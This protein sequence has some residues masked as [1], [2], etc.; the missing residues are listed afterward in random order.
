MT[1]LTASRGSLILQMDHDNVLCQVRSG[2]ALSNEVDALKTTEEKRLL[3]RKVIESII[4]HPETMCV[5]YAGNINWGSPAAY[6]KEAYV[7]ATVLAAPLF[8]QITALNDSFWF[9]F[10]QRDETDIY[11]KTFVDILKENGVAAELTDTFC[12][13]AFEGYI[14]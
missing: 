7:W 11:A 2:A 1:Q 10:L 5:S 4:R 9:N 13:D 8:V 14:P 6:M 3:C 12:E